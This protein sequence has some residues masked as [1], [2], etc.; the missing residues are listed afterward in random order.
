MDENDMHVCESN[1]QC[2]AGNTGFTSHMTY[3]ELICDDFNQEKK[4]NQNGRQEKKSI[5]LRRELVM[6]CC[7]DVIG[8]M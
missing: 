1:N 2:M 8:M 7:E 6:S 4:A 5:N 3:D